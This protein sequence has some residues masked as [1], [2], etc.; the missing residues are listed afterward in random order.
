L[1]RREE[2]QHDNESYPSYTDYSERHIPSTETERSRYEL[3]LSGCYPKEYWYSI[4]NIK[5]NHRSSVIWLGCSN[6][7]QKHTHPAREDRA[8]EEKPRSPQIADPSMTNYTAFTG[9]CV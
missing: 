3:V 9:V 5:A 7:Y 8:A 6:M 2:Q 1:T 4:G